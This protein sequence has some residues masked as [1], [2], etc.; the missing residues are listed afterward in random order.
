M[1][2]IAAR[3]VAKVAVLFVAHIGVLEVNPH[4]VT[5]FSWGTGAIGAHLRLFYIMR[6]AAIGRR[7]A[8]AGRTVVYGRQ[9]FVIPVWSPLV[10][11]ERKIPLLILAVT[12]AVDRQADQT[13]SATAVAG[14]AVIVLII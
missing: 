2:L 7:V 13:I 6:L 11:C 10:I 4:Q 14:V 8:V 5:G 3:R 1:G 12:V 9:V